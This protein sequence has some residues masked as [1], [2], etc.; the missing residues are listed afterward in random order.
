MN[1]TSTLFASLMAYLLACSNPAMTLNH[2]ELPIKTL[3]ISICR[4]INIEGCA[5][6]DRDLSL[7]SKTERPFVAG[8]TT[9]FL[10]ISTGSVL[11]SCSTLREA[12]GILRGL[13]VLAKR[14]VF[15]IMIYLHFISKMK[16]ILLPKCAKKDTHNSVWNNIPE[17]ISAFK[18]RDGFNFLD[19][20]D[21][22][23]VVEL[24]KA[25]L[26]A[27]VYENMQHSELIYHRSRIPDFDILDVITSEKNLESFAVEKSRLNQNL[28]QL[29]ISMA[30]CVTPLHYDKCHGLLLQLF[31]FKRFILFPPSDAPQLYLAQNPRH[32]SV[33]R[34]LNAF[35]RQP[36][37]RAWDLIRPDLNDEEYKWKMKIF[38][39]LEHCIPI[40]IDLEPGDI[41]YTPP[42]WLHEVRNISELSFLR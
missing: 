24:R 34:D 1:P 21:S 38:P 40:I 4:P 9:I 12:G 39:K 36:Y 22:I 25:Q 5:R 42:G 17:L 10:T 37:P 30:G 16:P 13:K 33:L 29:W 2:N 3:S 35:Y 28:A 18:S 7:L 11:I 20:H 31:G 27:I 8:K 23:E 41:L 6:T 32:T 14:K 19:S 26:R 15:E